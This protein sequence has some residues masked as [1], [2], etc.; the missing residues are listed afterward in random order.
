M[1]TLLILKTADLGKLWRSVHFLLNIY[2][3]Q[4]PSPLAPSLSSSKFFT[5][6]FITLFLSVEKS[7]TPTTPSPPAKHDAINERS[8]IETYA[9]YGRSG[10]ASVA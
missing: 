5:Q 10:D 6:F 3:F 7:S 2:N 4:T 1:R 9:A 8:L